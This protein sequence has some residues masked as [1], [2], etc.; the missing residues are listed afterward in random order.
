[1]ATYIPDATRS[2]TNDFPMRTPEG[3]LAPRT[4]TG[5]I[6]LP[7]TSEV[8][9]GNLTQATPTHPDHGRPASGAHRRETFKPLRRETVLL[10]AATATLAF[11]CLAFVAGVLLVR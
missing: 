4:T 1:M 10:W 7:I 5:E 3:L 6:A 11:A 8:M 2:T 9:L